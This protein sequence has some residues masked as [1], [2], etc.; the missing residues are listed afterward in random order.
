[1]IRFFR[2]FIGSRLGAVFAILF[3]GMV[4]F[5]FAA[6]DVENS[7]S[8]DFSLFSGSGAA[9]IGSQS[10]SE[11]ELQSR[12]QR[13]FEQQRRNTPGL[14]F[15]SFLE[16]DGVRVIYDQLISAISLTVFGEKQDIFVGKRLVD[17]RIAAIPA[18]HDA[19]GKFSQSAYRQLL[20]AQGI[21]EK[22]L[23]EDIAKEVAGD[24]LLRPAGMGARLPDGLVL[25]YASLLLES[26][27]GQ[28]A[29]LPSEAFAPKTPPTDAQVKDYYTRN[30]GRYA[31][32]ERRKL[33]YAIVDAA[34]FIPAATP[35][36]ADIAASYA[37][38]KARYAGRE[39]RTVEQLIL[40]TQAAAKAAL[41]KSLTDTAQAAGLAVG[42]LGPLDRATL[43]RQSSEALATLAFSSAKGATVG[44][45]RTALGWAVIR[46]AAIETIPATPLD[47]ARPDI[48]RVLTAQKVGQMMSDFTAKL[49]DQAADGATFDEIV[50]DNALKVE[51][52]PALLASGQDLDNTGYAPGPDVGALLKPAFDMEADDEPQLV[53]VAPQTRYALLDVADV[54][55]AAPAPLAKIR[56]LV[57][58]QYAQSVGMAKAKT[59][60]SNI[61]AQAAKGVPLASAL[62]QAGVPLPPVQKIAGKRA[63]LLR[64]DTPPPPPVAMLFSMAKGTVKMVPIG[65]DRGYYL[66]RLDALTQGDAAKVPGL[67]NRIRGDISRVA[68]DEYAGQFGRA[69]ERDL[70]VVRNAE[71]V[72]RVTAELSRAN[73]ATAQ[74]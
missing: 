30:A 21:S 37:R 45:V 63:E 17:A 59:V 5:A 66:V 69:I 29:A 48:V 38:D 2:R 60:A 53:Q 34:R 39:T 36:D 46:V 26:R 28:I 27:E 4:A 43:A 9:Q 54:V 49:E 7:T 74:Q 56:P 61:I 13:V 65:N 14:Q 44:P 20:S 35:S 10:L 71:A 11:A 52:T 72:K 19:S 58:Q 64:G 18:F 55:P 57:A 22:A 68:A 70:K 47:K 33:R 8:G 50:K 51:T 12:V 24:I 31:V 67:V 73:G 42:T 25:P 41:G 62:Q 3:L 32:P 40:P 23:R 15:A 1:M 6:G 16:Q